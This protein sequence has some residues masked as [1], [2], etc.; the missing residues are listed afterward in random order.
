MIHIQQ[1]LRGEGRS[2]VKTSTAGQWVRRVGSVGVV[3]FLVKGMVWVVVAA[4][5][6]AGYA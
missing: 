5:L 1:Q 3:F 2:T 4:W 6:A